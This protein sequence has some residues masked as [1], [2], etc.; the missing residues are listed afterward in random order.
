MNKILKQFIYLCSTG[1]IFSACSFNGLVNAYP[2]YAQQAYSNPREA[3]GRIACANCH[4]AQKPVSIESPSAVLPDT[5]F[6]AVV[7]IPYDV[8]KKQLLANGDRGPLNV[9]A[10]VILPEGFKLAPPSRISS[11]IKAKN[12]G[13]YISPYSSKAE[14]ILVVGPILGDK[15]RE[16]TFP[17]L[18]PDPEKSDAKYL[19]YP[20]YVGANRGRGQINPN[21]EKS[22]N[23]PILS[24]VVGQV[25]E[26][27]TNENG[28][29]DISIKTN[30]GSIIDE[31]IYKGLTV[32]VKPGQKV[33]KDTPL[34][35][36]PNVGGF[37]QTETEIVLQN[38]NRI[39]GY[40]VFC[41]AVVLCQIF[42][43]IK[44]KQFEKVQ[45][46]EMN[47]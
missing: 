40:L 8:S 6:E 32:S 38:S 29:S 11:E 45:A 5:V 22:N 37:G 19:K 46:A 34:T 4:L 23:N 12:K 16:I 27:R 47:F 9:G 41:L 17:V 13:I 43:V 28:T 7:K 20:I 36:D 39:I 35:F 1:F 24:S 3:N 15:N 2:I 31:K 44:K 33:T 14:N 30:D 25:T 42:L 10:V 26:I 18:A 21:G